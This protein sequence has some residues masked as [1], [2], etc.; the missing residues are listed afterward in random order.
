[1]S[2]APLSF[3]QLLANILMGY[4]GQTFTDQNGNLVPVDTSQGSLIYIKSAAYASALWGIQ[5]YIT[6]AVRQIFPQTADGDTLDSFGYEYNLPRTYGE[7]DAAY[8]ARIQNREQQ[9]PAGGNLNDY[10]QWALDIDNVAE[11]FPFALPRGLGTVDVVILANSLNT[12]SELPSVTFW[13][14]N[15]TTATTG[16]LIDATANF[17][18]AGAAVPAGAVVRNT[19]TGQETTVASV[20]SATQLTLEADIFPYVNCCY[21]VHFH[22]GTATAVTAGKLVNGAGA[23]SNATYPVGVGDLVQNRDEGTSTTVVSVDSAT[24]L[25]LAADIFTAPGQH[26]VVRSLCAQ[27]KEYV[28]QAR[29]VTASSVLVKAPTVLTQAVTM[30]GSGSSWNAGQAAID[31]KAYLDSMVPMQT[32]TRA[33]LVTIAGINGADD[34]TVTTPAANV[35]PTPYQMVRPGVITVS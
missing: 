6:W 30:T 35:V 16:K 19:V 20:D 29:P 34:V 10:A 1:M 33:R 26:Y 13:Q 27:V 25:T 14:G 28:D 18:A 12:G 5:A 15:V 22:S 9:P 11:A 3:D 24:Q 2:Y 4:A 17:T 7:S 32:L 23:F 8:L 31:V 21:T